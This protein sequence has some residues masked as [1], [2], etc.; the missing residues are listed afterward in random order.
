MLGGTL[1]K[2]SYGEVY[3]V[4]D[5]PDG[6]IV[7][8]KRQPPESESATRE[9]YTYRSLPEHPNVLS[10]LDAFV[11]RGQWLYLVFK[12]HNSCLEV[13]WQAARG[14]L[15]WAEARR[16]CGHVCAGLRHLHAHGVCHRDLCFCQLA[17]E[18]PR[19]HR[20]DCRPRPCSV[21]C[22]LHPRVERDAAGGALQKFLLLTAV[23][24]NRCY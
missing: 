12:Y 4:W 24:K 23:P 7:A 18:L 19:Q 8:L 14:C 1:A 20:P 2:G 3:A 16:Y 13:V 15:E 5:T 11:G 10:I 9:L 22:V 21:C 17:P 6:T